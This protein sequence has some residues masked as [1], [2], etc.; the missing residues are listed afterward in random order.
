MNKLKTI[1]IFLTILFLSK[2]AFSQKED[3]ISNYVYNW[4]KS[5]LKYL[6]A[7]KESYCEDSVYMKNIY[8]IQS[9]VTKASF[10]KTMGS[11]ERELLI[12]SLKGDLLNLNLNDLL[13]IEEFTLFHTLK[14]HVT[15]IDN[16]GNIFKLEK[17][18]GDWILISRNITNEQNE[19]IKRYDKTK[20]ID[21][22]N[23]GQVDNY[24]VVLTLVKDKMFS[25]KIL[26]N[27]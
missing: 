20:S 17:E 21:N 14:Y 19:Y 10:R 12:H 22:C 4:Y 27:E 5:N 15:I 16:S 11:T 13:I 6:D 24:Y 3:G 23:Y 25:T 7:T 9:L 8:S 18:K 1:L 26:C 2:P